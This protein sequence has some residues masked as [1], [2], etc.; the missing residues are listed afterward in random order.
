LLAFWATDD[1]GTYGT[2]NGPTG[3]S[4]IASGSTASPDGQQYQLWTK[5]A[6]GTEGASQNWTFST[7]P[8]SFGAIIGAWSNRLGAPA[9]GSVTTTAWN[10]TANASPVSLSLS[11]CTASASD[12]L[13]AF[14]FLD[15]TAANTWSFSTIAGYTPQT[16][17]TGTGTGSFCDCNLQTADNVSAGATGT[18]SLTA[19][20]SGG[21]AGW[22]GIL[23]QISYGGV[24]VTKTMDDAIL[25]ADDISRYDWYTQFVTS[26]LIGRISRAN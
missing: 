13:A 9:A 3:W 17:V 15:A 18:L 10:T 23:V 22:G 24:I 5:V 4:Q 6:D 25:L 26:G 19:T 11:G 14:S 7:G 20:A 2:L 12:D 16:T 1:N 21:S 8:H